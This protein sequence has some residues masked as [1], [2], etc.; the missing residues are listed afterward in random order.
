MIRNLALAA[1]AA[2]GVSAAANAAIP[3]YPNPGT[4]APTVASYTAPTAG[5]VTAWFLARSASFDS[6]IGFGINGAAPVGYC[7]PNT[8]PPGTSCDLGMVSAGDQIRFYLRVITN[9]DVFSTD[10]SDIFANNGGLN[11]AWHT[12]YAGGDFGVPAGLLLGWEDTRGGGDLD[13]NDHVFVF[14]FPGSPVIPEPATWAMM[15]AGFGLVGFAMRK[16]AAATA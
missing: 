12:A 5:L 11:H 7:L 8:S 10:P 16:R 6:E 2:F 1:I 3:V 4:E 9:G 15:I 14:K 13:Y